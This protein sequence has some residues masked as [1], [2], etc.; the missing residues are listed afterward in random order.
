MRAVYW[1]QFRALLM[2]NYYSM[3]NNY[4][5]LITLFVLPPFFFFNLV[6]VQWYA[7]KPPDLV[8]FDNKNNTLNA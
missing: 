1:A 3:R 5:L 7:N 2:K 8:N 4:S 6:V